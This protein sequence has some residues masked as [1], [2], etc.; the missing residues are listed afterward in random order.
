ML[1]ALSILLGAFT[2]AAATPARA[3]LPIASML[4][5]MAPRVEV[6][7]PGTPTTDEAER[8]AAPSVVV[9]VGAPHAPLA[10]AGTVV[11]IQAACEHKGSTLS[12]R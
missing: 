8:R 5:T 3:D 1:K 4:D 10:T 9:T 7:E 6:R 11:P 12:R 2:L